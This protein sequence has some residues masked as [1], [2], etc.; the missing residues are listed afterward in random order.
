MKK[1]IIIS[2][3]LVICCPSI[4]WSSK[5]FLIW[6]ITYKYSRILNISY[7]VFI[8]SPKFLYFFHFNPTLSN[9]FLLHMGSFTKT[10]LLESYSKYYKNSNGNC[11]WRVFFF[12][13]LFFACKCTTNVWSISIYST[14]SY[15][16]KLCAIPD[17]SLILYIIYMNTCMHI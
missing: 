16:C 6:L 5:D 4:I 9:R 8:K 10:T 7:V 2:W 1:I 14:D 11:F 12:I 13:Y 3:N 15:V 17:P